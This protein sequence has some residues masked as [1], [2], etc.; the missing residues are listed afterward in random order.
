MGWRCAI[1][2]GNGD[3]G[4]WSIYRAERIIDTGYREQGFYAG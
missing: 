4:R 2:G 3:K 1:C